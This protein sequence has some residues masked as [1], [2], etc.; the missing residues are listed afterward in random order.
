MFNFVSNFH[1]F[2]SE[3]VQQSLIHSSGVTVGALSTS[4]KSEHHQQQI[5]GVTRRTDC[6]DLS[7]F[8][9]VCVKDT[10]PVSSTENHAEMESETQRTVE[11]PIRCSFSLQ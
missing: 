9:Q 5:V 8:L 4:S 7:A 2:F 6:V 1:V 11:V 3:S 10:L